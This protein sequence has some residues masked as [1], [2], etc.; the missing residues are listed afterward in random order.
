MTRTNLEPFFLQGSAGRLYC[1]YHG[2]SGTERARGMVLYVPPFAEE[3]N[4]VR[5]QAAL[6]ARA[7]ARLGFAVLEIDLFGTGDSDG[8][9]SDA[10]WDLW[11]DDLA[12]GAGWL[13]QRHDCALIIWAVRLGTLLAVDLVPGL[14]V[15]PERLLFWQ[16]VVSGRTHLNQF[17]RLLV[18]AEM[19]SGEGKVTTRH[20]F[21]R[22]EQGLS[23][24]IAGY[25]LHPEL[26]ANLLARDLG[27]AAA[28]ALPPVSWYE[29]VAESGRPV[30]TVSRRV[31]DAW[32]ADGARVNESTVV[33]EPFWATAEIAVVPTLIEDTCAAA[34]DSCNLHA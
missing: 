19:I 11:L 22:L 7:L 16:P 12:R 27:G 17:F 25:E 20:L 2:P 9:F 29:I 21:D 8:D 32:R 15:R 26:F 24:E 30:S 18:A 5:R 1:I 10:R 34:V 6:Q 31:I 4:K 33:G 28:S 14:A 13:A 23:V 3:Q